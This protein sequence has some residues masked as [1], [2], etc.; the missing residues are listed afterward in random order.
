[1]ITLREQELREDLNMKMG[2]RKRLLNHIL[3]LRE[4]SLKRSSIIRKNS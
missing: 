4:L 1:M 3:F 2:D